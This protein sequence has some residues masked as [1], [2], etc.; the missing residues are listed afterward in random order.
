[1]RYSCSLAYVH[2]RPLTRIGNATHALIITAGTHP[3]CGRAAS[4]NPVGLGLV[5]ELLLQNI[6]SVTLYSRKL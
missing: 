4:A 1:M 6:L 5:S 2:A 3:W